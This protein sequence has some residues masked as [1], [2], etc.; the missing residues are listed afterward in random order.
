MLLG[1]QSNKYLLSTFQYLR[2]YYHHYSILFPRAANCA[3]NLTVWKSRSDQDFCLEASLKSRIEFLKRLGNEEGEKGFLGS[4]WKRQNLNSSKIC[5]KVQTW[6]STAAAADAILTFETRSPAALR[7]GQSLDRRL[8][9][10]S[11]RHW[12]GFAYLCS[13]EASG[14]SQIQAPTSLCL[15]QVKYL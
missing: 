9:G 4:P 10:S 2:H 7:P 5:L 14:Q 11:W 15:A 13:L 6:V 3:A 1:H 8:L 12:L